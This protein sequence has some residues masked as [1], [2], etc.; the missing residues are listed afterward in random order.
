MGPAA[1]GA[2]PAPASGLPRALVHPEAVKLTG[3]A[4]GG[5][6]AP[7]HENV[8][9]HVAAWEPHRSAHGARCATRRR[10]RVGSDA[11]AGDVALRSEKAA[12]EKSSQ[13]PA[14]GD[15]GYRA[16]CPRRTS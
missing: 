15:A 11:A 5:S 9:K 16:T 4:S 6:E 10:V 1:Q 3:V 2:H 12:V 14:R 7:Y 13:M 8:P